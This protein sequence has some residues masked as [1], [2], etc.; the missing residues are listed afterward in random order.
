MLVFYSKGVARENLGEGAE[1]PEFEKQ[2]GVLQGLKGLRKGSQQNFDFN[3][4]SSVLYNFFINICNVKR[5]FII[6]LMFTSLFCKVWVGGGDMLRGAATPSLLPCCTC[7]PIYWSISHRKDDNYNFN[8]KSCSPSCYNFL[9]SLLTFFS[10]MFL[11][12]LY[13]LKDFKIQKTT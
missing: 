10:N 6:F 4:I 11:L 2:G 12:N 9:L 3:A 5:F 8:F 13:F 1:Y 7:I